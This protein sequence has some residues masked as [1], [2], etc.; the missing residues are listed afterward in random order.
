M[1][2]E[3]RKADREVMAKAVHDLWLKDAGPDFTAKI[4]GHTDDFFLG[5]DAMMITLN[6]PRGVRLG[7]DF[8]RR[9]PQP[10]VFVLSWNIRLSTALFSTAFGDP[11]RWHFQKSTD[12]AYGFDS[13]CA[14]LAKR[15]AQL[16]SGEAFQDAPRA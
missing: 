13:L 1:L 14:V 8:D 11:N 3:K 7:I 10:G 16:A 12:V 15:K 5:K 6:G 2:S 9:S 4:E